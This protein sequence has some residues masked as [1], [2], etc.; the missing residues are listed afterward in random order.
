MPPRLDRPAAG[1]DEGTD[2]TAAHTNAIH[3]MSE[4]M[5][6]SWDMRADTHAT[7]QRGADSRGENSAGT[8]GHKLL[9]VGEKGLANVF[10]VELLCLKRRLNKDV[11]AV[12]S[13]QSVDTGTRGYRG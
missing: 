4:R 2:R 10:G 6:D 7:G 8:P 11:S 9:Q 5:A 13:R 3:D 12:K 1:Q